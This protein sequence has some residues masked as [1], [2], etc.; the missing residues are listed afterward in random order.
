MLW[1]YA[2]MGSNNSD[3]DK[4]YFETELNLGYHLDDSD[5]TRLDCFAVRMVHAL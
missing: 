1:I 3:T 2:S 4:N 5:V